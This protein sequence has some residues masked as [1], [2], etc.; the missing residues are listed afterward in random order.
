MAAAAAEVAAAVNNALDD[1]KTAK[2]PYYYHGKK[3]TFTARQLIDKVEE[4]AS[5]NATWNDQKKIVE[6]KQCLQDTAK[7]RWEGFLRIYGEEADQQDQDINTWAVFKKEF[8]RQFDP[9]GTAKALSL[10]ITDLKQKPSEDV[11][12]FFARVDTH[13]RRLEESHPMDEVNL[14]DAFCADIG[15]AGF[16]VAQRA[17]LQKRMTRIM[18]SVYRRLEG[19]L[20]TAGLSSD[21][22]RAKIQEAG[23]ADRIMAAFQ[24]AQDQEMILEKKKTVTSMALVDAIAEP[25][26]APEEDLSEVPSVDA[27]LNY[28]PEDEAELE[29][30]NAMR[31]KRKM[32]PKTKFFKSKSGS[33]S[34]PNK[35]DVVCRYKPCGKKGHMQADCFLRK[36]HGA[37]CVDE[38]GK[39]WKN[40]PKVNTSQNTASLNE[41]R[42]M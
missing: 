36:K 5:V 39:P 13:F 27:L 19:L 18:S 25:S 15:Y 16:T 34:G 37:P 40:Q 8:L 4:I 28:D 38:Q 9:T 24:L 20:Y 23:K 32:P 12:L 35:K 22:I 29:W 10:P 11:S 6:V 41:F 1:R 17:K 21:E 7:T 30:L 2:L 3:D 33:G 31:F 42:T 26:P 14:T